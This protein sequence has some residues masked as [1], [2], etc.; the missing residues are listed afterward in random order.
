MIVALVSRFHHC[1]AVRFTLVTPSGKKTWCAA[2]SLPLRLA[3]ACM[4]ESLAKM[5]LAEAFCGEMFVLP[6]ENSHASTSS[7]AV[8]A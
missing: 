2:H 3:K 7:S 8:R 5:L 1:T 4:R 6:M